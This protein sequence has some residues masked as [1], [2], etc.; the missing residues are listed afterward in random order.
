MEA[1]ELLATEL[2]LDRIEAELAID[3][4]PHLRAL[5]H[6]HAN[7]L[8]LP[9]APDVL[10]RATTL[11]TARA[12]LVH[13]L[14][15][16]RGLALVRLVAPIAL[17][18]DPAVAAARTA[19]PTW[20]ALAAL[21]VAR[22]AAAQVRFGRTAIEVVHRLHG[23]AIDLASLSVG[24][25][26]A[27]HGVDGRAGGIPRG[28]IAQATATGG[29]APER[30][31]AMAPPAV[32]GPG[33]ANDAGDRS[34]QLLELGRA[35]CV[36]VERGTGRGGAPNAGRRAA[37][38]EDGAVLGLSPAVAG[39]FE[40]DGIAVDD[41]AVT[42]AWQALRAQHGVDGIVRFERGTGARPR[43]FVVEPGREVAIAIPTQIATPAGRF[44]V[45]H[46]LGHAVAALAL[47]GGIPRVVDEAAAACV[48]RAIERDGDAWYS[49]LAA[50]ARARRRQLARLLDG[51]ERA[52]PALPAPPMV[53]ERPPW[54]LWHDPGAQAAYIAAE[55]L[56]DAIE[57]AIGAASGPGAFAA[58][59]SAWREAIDRL[60][61][62]TYAI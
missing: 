40:P 25:G 8:P 3:L 50:A 59:L 13:P 18:G 1:C 47:P 62:A 43:A 39:W 37:L 55:A 52:L 36:G 22:D 38:E 15:A 20:A 16:D 42:A 23:S 9:S 48:A 53:S 19:A 27:V 26:G 45:L 31:L 11:A 60:S 49:P 30:V 56:A 34:P 57:A 4:P 51:I 12:A 54:A 29:N 58:A 44:A 5:A 17:E 35:P 28:V 41:R 33:A 21:A 14:L 2:R 61:T 24:V 7:G 46:E 32:G 6:A 10:H